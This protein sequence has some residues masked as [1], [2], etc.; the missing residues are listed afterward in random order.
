MKNLFIIILILISASFASA[1]P[2][3]IT[4]KGLPLLSNV[5]TT[6]ASNT[7]YNVMAETEPTGRMKSAFTVGISVT[8]SPT[9]AK[10]NLE[11]SING[12][13]WVIIGSH[14]LSQAELD[15]NYALF[16]VRGVD[17][18]YVRGNLVVLGGGSSPS[19]S[20]DIAVGEY[21]TTSDPPAVKFADT[22]TIDAF[23]RL[24][25]AEPF[26]LWDNKNIHDR[27]SSVWEEPI[28]GAII[29]YENLVGGPFQVAEDITGGTSGSIGTITAVDGGALT[30]TF[31]VNHNDFE[32][33]E[34]ITGSV[35]G[36]T[37]DVV[38]ANTGS[39]IFHTR[40]EASVTLQVGAS[41]GDSAV[42]H[43]HR[44]FSYIPG[45]SQRIDMTFVLGSAV[46]NV[47]K[48]VGYFDALN[49]LFLEQDS[50]GLRFV[51]RTSTSGSTVDNLIE[52]AD[53]NLDT[54]DGNGPSGV[55]LDA[56]KIQILIID[57]QW[58]G[59]GRVR[60]GFDVNGQIIYAHEVIS[61]NV[62]AVPY[63]STPSLPVRYEIANTGAT[64]STNTFKE[65][66]SAVVSEGGEAISG[67]GFAKS[68]DTTGVTITTG[69]LQPVILIRLKNTFG[70]DSGPNRKTVQ[71]TNSGVFAL[72]NTIH[73]EV[74]HFH[75]PT[76]T[77]GAWVSVDDHSAVEYNVT[78]TA[79]T[80]QD[81]HVIDEEYVPAGQAGKGAPGIGRDIDKNNQH[82]FITQ[83]TDSTN[84]EVFGI[85]AERLPG[86]SDATAYG[87]LIWIEFD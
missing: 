49:G 72:T 67:Q 62:L 22:P 20:M 35:S 11:G 45:K 6:G 85:V 36:A 1:G 41:S 69:S 4:T 75:A 50:T 87:H 17:V 65:I 5:S 84:S 42:R 78:A 15:A 31:S 73:Y 68:N 18:A 48:R 21:G 13:D 64:A 46:T 83:N 2:N 59:G 77:G 23:S 32:V 56:T 37:A 61:S 3:N 30:V 7:F 60:F 26:S 82:A 54:L 33:G 80:A 81:E 28:I 19:V 27:N 12:S 40:D 79:I 74:K 39:H 38:T 10:V 25:T 9:S 43:T 24:R 86:G 51:R 53:W 55:T 66:C 47:R 16:T 57:F 70:S 76:I 44:Y 52:Q 8:G 14:N 29:V 34:Q 63:M 58:L 71:L